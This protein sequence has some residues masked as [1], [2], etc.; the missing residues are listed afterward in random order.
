MNLDDG[1]VQVL[2]GLAPNE[3]VVTSGQFMLD[4]ESKLREGRPENDGTQGACGGNREQEK[5][6]R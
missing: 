1:K 6:R 5:K 4:S 3:T 2:E